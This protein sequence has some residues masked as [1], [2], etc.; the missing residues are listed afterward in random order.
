MNKLLSLLLFTSL[1]TSV[2]AE[3]SGFEVY[4]QYCSACHSQGMLGAPMLGDRKD[5]APRISKGISILNYN[6]N[7]G[8]VGQNGVMPKKGGYLNLSD[9]AVVNA[10]KYMVD[11]SW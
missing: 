5:W 8:Y 4:E 1:V 2:H 7:M 10:V 9:E 6:A 3:D 11:E